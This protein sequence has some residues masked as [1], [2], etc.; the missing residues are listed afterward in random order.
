MN[1]EGIEKVIYYNYN[2]ERINKIKNYSKDELNIVIKDLKKQ[3]RDLMNT[4]SKKWNETIFCRFV[5]F[6]KI[7]SYVRK[8]N[9]IKFYNN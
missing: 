3:A 9:I 8:R 1:Y 4:K 5:E 7:C 2:L 6:I